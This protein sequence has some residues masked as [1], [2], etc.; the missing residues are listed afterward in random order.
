LVIESLEYTVRNKDTAIAEL[1]LQLKNLTNNYNTQLGSLLKKKI[2]VQSKYT[3]FQD[4]L[5]VDT[6][7]D[8]E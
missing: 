4:I 1:K 8:N 6:A 2:L 7:N 3:N 5:R